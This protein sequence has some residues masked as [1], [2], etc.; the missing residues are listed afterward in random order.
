MT[1]GGRRGGSGRDRY[2]CRTVQRRF[3]ID[4]SLIC[5]MR[6]ARIRNARQAEPRRRGHRR[7]TERATDRTGPLHPGLGLDTT[8]PDFIVRVATRVT[9]RVMKPL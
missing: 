6:T 9:P 3:L 4:V 1:Y 7:A 2:L 5:L 8:S